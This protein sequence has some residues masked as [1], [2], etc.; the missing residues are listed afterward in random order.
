MS[1]PC[2]AQTAQQ[3]R[4]SLSVLS[5]QIENSPT[6]LDLRLKKAAVNI[7]LGQ[8]EYAIDEYSTVLRIES[9][10]LAALF[11]RAYAYVNLRRYELALNDYER[12]LDIAPFNME[13]RLGLV[14]TYRKLNRMGEA[15][16]QVNMLVEHFPDSAVAYAVR[17][18]LEKERKAYD[19]A[20]YDWD[21][22]ISLQPDNGDYK[23]S[24]VALLLDMGKRSEARKALDG[25]VL[26]GIP[27][28]MLLE[29]YRKCND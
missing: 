7:N 16:D 21:K 22:A 23:I 20:L 2:A 12:F 6:S 10:N 27:R 4:D 8:W 26:D 9:A 5:L 17:A 14:H 11:Y 28:G 1:V 29:W 24:K 25:M 3:W 15:I 13:A 19:A 18:D